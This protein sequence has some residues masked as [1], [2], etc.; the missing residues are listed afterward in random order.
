MSTP[1][2]ASSPTSTYTI[3][4]TPT[5][6]P[7]DSHSLASILLLLVSHGHALSVPTPLTPPTAAALF[8]HALTDPATTLYLAR[9][10]DGTIIGTV[11][12]HLA[13]ATNAQHRACISK[14]LVH[15]DHHGRGV[16]RA[17]L[18]A[19]EAGARG[20]G[21]TLMHLDTNAEAE[22]AV[23]LYRRAG[24]VEVGDVPDWIRLEDGRRVTS[25]FFWKVL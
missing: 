17:L 22:A 1:P 3:H 19:A 18:G 24:Y 21:R 23:G 7:A 15:P 8:T 9:L 11:Q 20:A 4:P 5:L 14:M 13:T 16:G 10:P 12:L 2:P 25:K 6:T